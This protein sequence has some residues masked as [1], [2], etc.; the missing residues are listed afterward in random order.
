[1]SEAGMGKGAR[2][3][4]KGVAPAEKGTLGLLVAFTCIRHGLARTFQS[5]FWFGLSYT[6]GASPV[7]DQHI[8]APE[9][10]GPLVVGLIHARNLAK[11]ALSALLV[12]EIGWGNGSMIWD[13]RPQT[14]SF[15]QHTPGE[16]A[17]EIGP[18]DHFPKTEASARDHCA[19]RKYIFLAVKNNAGR[20]FLRVCHTLLAPLDHGL[21]FRH[22]QQHQRSSST[23]SA[24]EPPPTLCS[25]VQDGLPLPSTLAPAPKRQTQVFERDALQN[26]FSRS[27]I[28]LFPNLIAY[29]SIRPETEKE[30][31][32]P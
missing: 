7:L 19:L 12:C 20:I 18:H 8:S 22:V 5:R 31:G 28:L 15:E 1:M 21:L 17:F 11:V 4:E 24:P 29:S 2:E 27:D 6:T 26:R 3:E 10:G 23:D 14:G 25:L 32:S 16:A 9:K 30:G 13:A